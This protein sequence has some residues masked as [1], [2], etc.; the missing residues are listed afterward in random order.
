MNDYKTPSLNTDG[1]ILKIH[2]DS[3]NKDK[4]K[5][6]SLNNRAQ[7]QE[8]NLINASTNMSE[9]EFDFRKQTLFYD[10]L[11]AIQNENR[12]RCDAVSIANM[13]AKFTRQARAQQATYNAYTSIGGSVLSKLK[14][15]WYVPSNNDEPNADPKVQPKKTLVGYGPY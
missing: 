2:Y 11:D 10:K 12:L 15:K 6:G 5:G 13:N 9:T 8:Y 14:S 7:Q 1:L 4:K 3:Y